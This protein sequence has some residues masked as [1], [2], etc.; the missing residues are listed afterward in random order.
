MNY[1]FW[2]RHGWVKQTS[3][4]EERIEELRRYLK[5]SSWTVWQNSN[6]LVQYKTAVTEVQEKNVINANA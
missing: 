6:F 2:V 4:I 5:V 1:S 3:K